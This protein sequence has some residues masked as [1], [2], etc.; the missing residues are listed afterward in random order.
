MTMMTT[1]FCQVE[2]DL[3]V[4]NISETDAF[5]CPKCWKLYFT[6]VDIY[7]YELHMVIEEEC[8]EHVLLEGNMPYFI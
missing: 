5:E 3:S 1:E 6:Q 4:S 2:T 8:T 7:N